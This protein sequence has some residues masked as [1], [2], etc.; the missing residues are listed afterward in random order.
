M[1]FSEF[2]TQEH[3]KNPENEQFKQYPLSILHLR[4]RRLFKQ[5]HFISALDKEQKDWI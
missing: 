2:H 1:E 5:I 4:G 3:C